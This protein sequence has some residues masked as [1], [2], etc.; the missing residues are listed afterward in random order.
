MTASCTTLDIATYRE[1]R[2]QVA[3]NPA[4]GRGNF[5]TVTEWR[6]GAQAVTRARSFTIG[7]S[8]VLTLVDRHGVSA[9]ISAA[10]H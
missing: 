1:T 4:D 8:P 10:S 6:D 7:S 2:D 5:E 3:R 9:P